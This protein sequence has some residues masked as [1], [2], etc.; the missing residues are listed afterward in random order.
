MSIAV[1]KC[2]ELQFILALVHIY[3]KLTDYTTYQALKEHQLSGLVKTTKN[4]WC[5]PE[6]VPGY[7]QYSHSSFLFLHKFFFFLF[8]FRLQKYCH[9]GKSWKKLVIIPND[10][11]EE[12]ADYI[13]WYAAGPSIHVK[14]VPSSD[15][16]SGE[17]RSCKSCGDLRWNL[18]CLLQ[19]KEIPT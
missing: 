8:K 3:F 7:M 13:Q 4:L 11:T 16:N 2:T 10:R 9:D 18:F 17:T 6:S 1:G 5:G 12:I 19:H 15:N 14:R